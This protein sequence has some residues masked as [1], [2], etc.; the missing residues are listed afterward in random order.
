MRQRAVVPFLAERSPLHELI[1]TYML[2]EGDR[3]TANQLFVKFSWVSKG[4]VPLFFCQQGWARIWIFGSMPEAHGSSG[5]ALSFVLQIQLAMSKQE[6]ESLAQKVQ[7][8]CISAKPVLVSEGRCETRPLSAWFAALGRL[9][10]MCGR[11]K[12]GRV[13]TSEEA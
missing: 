8:Q 13:Q 6:G 4:V 5:S 7:D 2:R 12:C 11:V 9:P 1:P 10:C 3:T